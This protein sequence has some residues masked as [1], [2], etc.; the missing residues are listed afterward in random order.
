M[1]LKKKLKTKFLQG[2]TI[3]LFAQLAASAASYRIL[4]S[5][6]LPDSGGLGNAAI[7]STARR[8]Y[9][10]QGTDVLVFDLDR[11]AMAGKIHNASSVSAVAVASDLGRGF[12][13]CGRDNQVLVFDLKTLAIVDT[14]K[15]GSG[16]RDLVYDRASQRVFVFNRGSKDLT[17]ID[18]ATGYVAGTVAL[19]GKPQGPATDEHGHV[20]VTL[21][22]RS[23]LVRF[24]PANLE[25]LSH[26]PLAPCVSPSAV[27]L[28]VKGGRAFVACTNKTMAIVDA[29]QGNVI[30]TVPVGEGRGA[31]FDPEHKSI[32]SSNGDGTLTVIKQESA[33]KYSVLESVK[34]E[35]AALSI[36]VDYK[37]HKIYLPCVRFGPTPKPTKADPQPPPAI[38]PGT[39][40]LLIVSP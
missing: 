15:V 33:D 9:I 11:N 40:K 2:L 23:E 7:D 1:L 21:E 34:T 12:I 4:N 28:D 20:Y 10:P 27:A 24:D 19:G 29:D 3:C 30:T 31:A 8:L 39:S 5:I 32:F 6:P 17:G 25:V 16:P 13:S 38:V 35:G 36:I 14:V 22:D 37:T 18:G 26:W